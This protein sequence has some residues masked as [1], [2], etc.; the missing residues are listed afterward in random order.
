MWAHTIAILVGGQSKRMGSPK[1]EVLLPNGKTMMEMMVQFAKK[2]ARQTVV[3]GQDIDGFISLKDTRIK[4][5][6]V[7]G[8]EALLHSTLDSEYLVLGCDMPRITT[9]AIKPLLQSEGTPAF[10]EDKKILGLPLKIKADQASMCSTY[11][12]SGGRSIRG[13]INKIPHSSVKIN[14]KQ[15][16]FLLSL[17]TLEDIKERF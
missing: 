11:L 5:G 14:Q 9:E 8:I 15:S 17:N 2:A 7:A 4:T 3:V 13:L 10:L 16:S 12:D 1:H 6:P